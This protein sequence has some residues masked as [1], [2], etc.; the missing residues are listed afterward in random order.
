MSDRVIRS[1]QALRGHDSAAA[2]VERGWRHVIGTGSAVLLA[3][4]GLGA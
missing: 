1:P 3:Q 4:H 2:A